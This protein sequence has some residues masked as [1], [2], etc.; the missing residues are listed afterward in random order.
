MFLRSWILTRQ[1]FV[2]KIIETAVID[3]KRT[4]HVLIDWFL[5]HITGLKIH[6]NTRCAICSLKRKRKKEKILYLTPSSKSTSVFLLFRI[7]A[8]CKQT[9]SIVERACQSHLLMSR[10]FLM[11][12]SAPFLSSKPSCKCK[13]IYVDKEICNIEW[14]LKVLVSILKLKVP[15]IVGT[16]KFGTCEHGWHLITSQ[17]L[18]VPGNNG[19]VLTRLLQPLL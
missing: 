5:C 15:N 7:N 18:R 9:D 19:P 14:Y 12:I 10:T 17:I 6:E 4:E 3:G 11:Q 2:V 13:F 16:S 1:H 8:K